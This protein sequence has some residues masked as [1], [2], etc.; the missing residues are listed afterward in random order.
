MDRTWNVVGP[1]INDDCAWLDPVTFDELG[2]PNSGDKDIS[3]SNL[4]VGTTEER[5]INTKWSISECSFD[6]LSQGD[7]R[8]PPIQMSLN[9]TE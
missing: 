8:Y 6:I 3:P 9:D 1:D 4:V 7:A 5:S 2:F